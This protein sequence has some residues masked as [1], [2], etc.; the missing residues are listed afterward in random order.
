[1]LKKIFV[2]MKY[3]LIQKIMKIKK[4]LSTG[5][6]VGIVFGI[7]AFLICLIIAIIFIIRRIKAANVNVSDDENTDPYI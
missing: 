4:K 1:M 3:I 2:L 6:I 5:A 7:L